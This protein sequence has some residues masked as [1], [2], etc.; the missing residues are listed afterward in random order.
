MLTDILGQPRSSVA[1]LYHDIVPDEEADQSGVNTEWSWRYKLPPDRFRSHLQVIDDS[2]FSPTTIDDPGEQCVYLTFDD[3]GAS[4]TT[5]AELLEEFG[6]RGHFFVITDRIGD[7]NY[8]SWDEIGDL[9]N[10]GHV[11]GSHTVTHADLVNATPAKRRTELIDSRAVLQDR[12]GVGDAVSIPLGQYNGA[13]FDA[14]A[15]AGYEYTFTSEPERLP[16]DGSGRIG[17]WSVRHYTTAEEIRKI[18]Y[19]N[20][21]YYVRVAGRWKSLR[22]IKSV[23]GR[24]R[25]VRIRDAII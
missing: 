18:L 17:R 19:A 1:L 23:V 22:A 3:G 5:A 10:R 14:V 20:P 11:V 25:F 15:D 6:F 4:A 7:P 9:V 2:E 13:V 24:D 8:L 16:S 21:A 12:L